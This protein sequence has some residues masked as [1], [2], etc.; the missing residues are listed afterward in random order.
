MDT[1]SGVGWA[2]WASRLAALAISGCGGL[3]ADGPASLGDGTIPSPDG[4]VVPGDTVA[5]GGG[6]AAGASQDIGS[7]L[8]DAALLAMADD[9]DG[10][11]SSQRRFMR[12]VGVWHLQNPSDPGM[13]LG[14][15]LEPDSEVPW[16]Q[17]RRDVR[18]MAVTK[19]ANSVS[20][21][22]L[23][24]VPV[25]TSPDAL[26]QRI[27]LRDY[28]WE[29]ALSVDA[30]GYA[31]GWEAI[32]ARASLAVEY[33]GPDADRLR[34]A[35][36]EA[37][38]WLLAD[39]FVAAVAA[40][41]LYYSLLRLPG[42]LP[43]LISSLEAGGGSTPLRARFNT[44]G[45]STS[46]RVVERRETSSGRAYWQAL[47]FATDE[48]GDDLLG[49]PLS[50]VADATEL[51][52]P[53]TNGLRGYFVSDANGQRVFE[54]PLSN[55]S[56]VDSAQADAVLRNPASCFSC[57]NA[58]LIPFNDELRQRLLAGE[59][60]G[61]SPEQTSAALA[62]YPEV[63]VLDRFRGLDDASYV[64]GVRALGI[65]DG[66]ADPVSRVFLDFSLGVGP[67]RA[68]GELFVTPV[69]L[70]QSLPRS[71]DALRPLASESG[72]VPRVV[73]VR[74]YEQLLCSLHPRASNRPSAC[75]G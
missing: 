55:I 47:D 11:P 21:G 23:L 51:I 41:E 31:N 68:A 25:S 12:Y 65:P 16:P 71:S 75:R 36:G 9:L 66:T 17:Q 19:V 38:P 8:L 18:R 24:R 39:D 5:P 35:T 67:Q 56:V 15:P 44:S 64:E 53:L 74:A 63:R 54:S 42:S 29:R 30:R 34:S 7:D 3:A 4:V 70:Q 59:L 52:F 26:F 13:G 33:V 49:Q 27:D 14:N 32:V 20:T 73:F 10:V 45:I 50:S 6:G 37:V 1:V 60:A 22:S 62:A 48:R 57:H 69:V 61:L 2:R 58:G 43:E 72:T 46:P 28:G 40:G